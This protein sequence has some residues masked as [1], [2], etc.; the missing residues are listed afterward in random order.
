MAKSNRDARLL[1]VHRLDNVTGRLIDCFPWS[2]VGKV[3]LPCLRYEQTSGGIGFR[4]ES[5]SKSL[6]ACLYPARCLQGSTS[7]PSGSYRPPWPYPLKY[8]RRAVCRS[9]LPRGLAGWS[10]AIQWHRRRL[11]CEQNPT[12]PSLRSRGKPSGQSAFV[13]FQSPRICRGA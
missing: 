9:P 11:S 5:E 4:D 8:L 10:A 12:D 2:D 3:V 13:C 6:C 7:P 1:S